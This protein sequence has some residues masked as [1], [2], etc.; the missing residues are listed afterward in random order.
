MSA[1]ARVESVKRRAHDWAERQEPSSAPGVTIGAWRRYEAV[2]GPLQSALLSLYVLVA[3]LPA[4]LVMTEY[5]DAHPAALANHMARH[6]GLSDNT[7][8]LLRG[9]LVHD[10]THE[11]GSA[12]LAV[13]GALF[14]GLGYGRV[15]QLVHARAWQ[16][17]PPSRQ[18]DQP[19]YALVLVGLYG[20][21]LVLLVQLTAL[22]GGPSWA[23]FALTPGWIALLV[24]YF[25]WVARV[26]THK[27]IGWRDLFPGAMLTAVVLVG[28]M[29][30]SR[31]AIEPW[32]NF[33]ARDYGGF[34]VVM[35]IYF[36][37]LLSSAVIVVAASLAPALAE[38]RD[39]RTAGR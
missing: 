21:I 4:L 6:Y 8:S 13:A 36:W 32:I 19:R 39:L 37:I 28:L 26:L 27:Q 18:A 1:R 24:V 30:L 33:Y 11:L 10:R 14:F 16:I 2:D 29:W 3:V 22:S 17:P 25:A 38:R 34:G 5:L 23:R 31:Y 7:A 35:A 20:L 9:V 12:L 15:L